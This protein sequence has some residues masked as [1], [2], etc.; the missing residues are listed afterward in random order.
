M[1]AVCHEVFVCLLMRYIFNL[2]CGCAGNREGKS[3]TGVLIWEG[4]VCLDAFKFIFVV[5]LDLRV[6]LEC[7][8]F[9]LWNATNSYLIHKYFSMLL[10]CYFI[11]QILCKLD[12]FAFL[13]LWSFICSYIISNIL[14]LKNK[15][16]NENKFIFHKTEFITDGVFKKSAVFKLHWEQLVK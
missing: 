4:C 12:V 11:L 5:S 2:I 16:E 8:V 6:E 15:D 14:F 3:R 1:L 13:A 7:T 9:M 10:I